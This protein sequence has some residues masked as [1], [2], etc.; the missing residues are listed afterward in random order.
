MQKSIKALPEY[1]F[2]QIR[3][4]FYNATATTRSQHPKVQVVVAP[5]APAPRVLPEHQIYSKM[6]YDERVKA[7]VDAELESQETSAKERLSTTNRIVRE[8]YG[9]ESEEVKEAVR[10]ERDAMVQKA[11]ADGETITNLLRL[12]EEAR[13]AADYAQ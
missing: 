5:V 2:Q 9:Q 12:E 7:R 3:H 1:L 4:W 13:T 6:F 8:M 11:K 10:K